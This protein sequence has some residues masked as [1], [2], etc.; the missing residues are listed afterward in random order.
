MMKNEFLAINTLVDT[1]NINLKS[2]YVTHAEKGDIYKFKNKGNSY[3]CYVLVVK[4][5]MT[6]SMMDS[7]TV[8]IEEGNALFLWGNDVKSY[9]FSDETRYYW[10]YF[11]LIGNNLILGKT[12]LV[13]TEKTASSIQKCLK[14]LHRSS[15]IELCR[16]NMIFVKLV[17]NGVEKLKENEY[18]K[19]SFYRKAIEMS[20]DFIKDNLYDLPSIQELANMSGMSLKQYRKHFKRIMGDFPAKYIADQKM[21][22]V[23]DC[24]VNTDLTVNQIAEMLNFSSPYYL[25]SSFKK[26][27]NCSPKEYRNKHRE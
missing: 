6:L 16:A 27:F 8:D 12:F 10:V 2:I 17:L 15:L 4:G 5:K 14:L 3:Y 13:D 25:S 7:S 18:T 24:L 9:S 21:L 26:V 19:K 22:L 11:S 20:V 23:R 1:I